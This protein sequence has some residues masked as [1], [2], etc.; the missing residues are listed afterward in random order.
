M[1]SR[2]VDQSDPRNAA[3]VRPPTLP[4]EWTQEYSVPVYD[5]FLNAITY[6]PRHM[7]PLLTTSL[8][9]ATSVISP[10]HDLT[11]FALLFSTAQV[12]NIKPLAPRK[13]NSDASANA[14]A[15]MVYVT[16][17]VFA[18][19]KFRS[20]RDHLYRR[21]Q[22]MHSYSMIDSAYGPPAR[23]MKYFNQ[24]NSVSCVSFHRFS[25]SIEH[26]NCCHPRPHLSSSLSCSAMKSRDIPNWGRAMCPRPAADY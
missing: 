10:Y 16:L 25:M 8:M 15:S 19:G 1:A 23:K 14:Y 18:N 4:S 20:S 22:G 9:A 13:E 26:T 3:A 21:A 6:V 17:N 11:S 24:R 2:R 12:A 5:L 7:T